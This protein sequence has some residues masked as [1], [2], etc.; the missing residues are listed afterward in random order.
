MIL[1]AYET[2]GDAFKAIHEPG[3][4]HFGRIV[5]E[6]MHMI[7]FPIELHQ[8]RFEV[9]ADGIKDGLEIARDL[10]GEYGPAIFGYKDQMHVQVENTVSAMP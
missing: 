1:L 6:Q 9:L 5:H 7:F 4:R 8:G 10:P 2:G 3:Y